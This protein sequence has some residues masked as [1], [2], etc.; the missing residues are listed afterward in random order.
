MTKSIL[1]SVLLLVCL[2]PTTGAFAQTAAKLA[3][4]EQDLAILQ[5]DVQRLREEVQDLRA[6]V[7]RLQTSNNNAGASNN[8][9]LQQ[10]V[11]ALA[12]NNA[13][14]EARVNQRM[15]KLVEE[16]N[17][18][19]AR[20]SAAVNK[21][22]ADKKTGTPSTERA[23]D[24][25]PKDMPSHGIQYTVKP[26]DSF[27]RIARTNRSRVAWIL[28]ANNLTE[29]SILRPGQILY[30]PQRPTPAPE[31]LAHPSPAN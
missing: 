21:A 30:V 26:N 12:N 4:I 24:S 6:A 19:L 23:A 18:A 3:G 15:T 7:A 25:P 5:Q 22:L 1:L 28:A 27:N 14:I 8:A 17:Q 10:Q 2:L 29:K 16:I 31:P 9:A 13:Q 20:Q 11:T